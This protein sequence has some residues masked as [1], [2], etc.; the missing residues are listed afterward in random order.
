MIFMHKGQEM[1]LCQAAHLVWANV[2]LGR[3]S[4]CV[5]WIVSH[6]LPKQL[7]KLHLMPIKPVFLPL[8]PDCMC[9]IKK[10]LPDPFSTLADISEKVL[11]SCRWTLS[12]QSCSLCEQYESI[13][14]C[15]FPC[16][17]SDKACKKKNPY[18]KDHFGI[19]SEYTHLS[20][21]VPE[22]VNKVGPLLGSEALNCAALQDVL[23][24]DTLYLHLCC[25]P[26]KGVR[27]KRPWCWTR[28]SWRVHAEVGEGF[29]RGE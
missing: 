4:A 8:P 13:K 27:V 2:C 7:P 11:G 24:N 25:L 18:F 22:Q 16:K 17:L 1:S 26:F 15:V 10:K 29:F 19:S 6:Q 12:P 9:N 21:Q 3:C 23:S 14:M 5:F 20:S 28:G